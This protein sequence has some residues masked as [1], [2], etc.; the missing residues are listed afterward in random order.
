MNKSKN[1]SGFTLLEV[2]IVIII[3][4]VLASLALPRFFKTV[5]YSR[6]MEAL[7]N[8]GTLRNAMGRCYMPSSSYTPCSMGAL[9]VEDP[10][11]SPGTHFAYTIP[12]AL[13]QPTTFTLRATRNSIDGGNVGDTINITDAGV[14]SGNGAFLGIR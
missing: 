10:G 5:E 1:K 4:G 6:A 3:V 11:T 14:K 8:L 7:S 12:G 13:L 2:I 9:D